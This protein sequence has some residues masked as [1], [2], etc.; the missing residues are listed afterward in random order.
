MLPYITPGAAG[1]GAL[2]GWAA[3]RMGR[4]RVFWAPLLGV[5]CAFANVFA[6]LAIEG[7]AGDPML[8]LSGHGPLHQPGI[9]RIGALCCVLF[10]L[11]LVPAGLL[12]GGV[13]T[14]ATWRGRA[15][16]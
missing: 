15:R 9:A 7:L 6:S 14:L 8:L 16:P 10:W 1:L 3:G 2:L 13:V 4:R 11:F 5:A 12:A